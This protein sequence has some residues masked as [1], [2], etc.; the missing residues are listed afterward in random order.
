MSEIEI[1][2]KSYK[3]NQFAGKVTAS[4]KDRETKV[5]SSGGGD[6]IR[7]GRVRAKALKVSSATTV[8]DSFYLVNEEDN[9]EKDIQLQNWDVSLRDGHDAQVVWIETPKSNHE[10]Y[11]AIYN[12]NLKKATWSRLAINSI[13]GAH[14]RPQLWGG[15]ALA[16]ILGVIFKSF[17]IGLIVIVC[18]AVWLFIK[19]KEVKLGLEKAV[20]AVL[21]SA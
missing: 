1:N 6:T 17:V 5:S 4:S 7:D 15:L 20:D 9:S 11:A 3:I 14:Y 8:H 13:A 19:I 21:L 12:K 16:I 2:G 18:L 10:H